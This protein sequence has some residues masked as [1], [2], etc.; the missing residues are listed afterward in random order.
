MSSLLSSISSSLRSVVSVARAPA[1][2]PFATPVR[3]LSKYKLKTHKGTAKRWLAVG[4]D[5]EFKRMKVNKS[6]LNQGMSS[7]RFNRLSAMA[8]PYGKAMTRTLHR[9]MP[10]SHKA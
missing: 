9:L 2:T 1:W 7:S 8:E 5:R 6:H 4:N 3:S 10:Y